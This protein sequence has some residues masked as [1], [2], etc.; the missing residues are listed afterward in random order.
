LRRRAR[1]SLKELLD[2]QAYFDQPAVRIPKLEES[3]RQRWLRADID[4]GI[5]AVYGGG[6]LWPKQFVPH[7]YREQLNND[8]YYHRVIASPN[9][10]PPLGIPSMPFT[11]RGTTPPTTTRRPDT[12]ARR[13]GRRRRART[14][15]C[16]SSA[17]LPPDESKKAAP[18]NN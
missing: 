17:E 15:G 8:D 6:H 10:S 18:S 13:S 14:R 4:P 7:V 16:R 12:Q 11:P 5:V 9:V 3:A 2:D 1:F